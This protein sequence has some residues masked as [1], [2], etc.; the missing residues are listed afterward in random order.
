[1]LNFRL[2]TPGHVIDIN[3]LTKLSGIAEANG[4]MRVSAM[5]SQCDILE[6][7][8]IQR[9]MPLLHDALSHAGLQQAPN[10][11]ALGAA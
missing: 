1:M 4:V 3:R 11:G 7:G 5:T 2:A 9:A 10:R 8:A 6:S